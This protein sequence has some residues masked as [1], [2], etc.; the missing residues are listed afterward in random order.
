[1]TCQSCHLIVP[2]IA[3][4]VCSDSELKCADLLNQVQ[5]IRLHC[6]RRAQFMQ[7]MDQIIVQHGAVGGNI[8]LSVP[9][10]ARQHD[11]AHIA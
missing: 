5:L 4:G 8:T 1:M 10:H 2:S 6:R 7:C 3:E 11:T 9:G